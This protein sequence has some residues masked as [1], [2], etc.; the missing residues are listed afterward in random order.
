M[1]LCQ[2]SSEKH[3]NIA[4]ISVS[5]HLCFAHTKHTW[6]TVGRIAVASNVS[7]VLWEPQEVF[8]TYSDGPKE[9][10]LDRLLRLRWKNILGRLFWHVNPV[11]C[12]TEALLTV[13]ARDLSLCRRSL[14]ASFSSCTQGLTFLLWDFI[15]IICNLCMERLYVHM[16]KEKSGP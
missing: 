4:D 2:I 5:T 10:N 11:R 16:K 14:R 7:W 6:P 13:K 1:C 3:E 8:K 15:L 9:V 12:W